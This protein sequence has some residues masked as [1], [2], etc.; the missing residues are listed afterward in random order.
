MM[1]DI[2]EGYTMIMH[3]FQNKTVTANQLAKL[4]IIDAI[5]SRA[6]DPLDCHFEA[7]KMTAKEEKDFQKAFNKQIARVEKFLAVNNTI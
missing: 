7:N 5:D 2:K 6:C 4:I 1:R 3:L